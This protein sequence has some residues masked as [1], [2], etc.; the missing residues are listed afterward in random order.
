VLHDA[1]TLCNTTSDFR[2][3]RLVDRPSFDKEGGAAG[4]RKTTFIVCDFRRIE[5]PASISRRDK[6]HAPHAD[7]LVECNANGLLS[8]DIH[9]WIGV[10]RNDIPQAHSTAMIVDSAIRLS[11][12]REEASCPA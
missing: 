6:S 3:R 11:G 2:R 4:S 7:L 1:A 8:N 5:T 9:P 10:L 12:K